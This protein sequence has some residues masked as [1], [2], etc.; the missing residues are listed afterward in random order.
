[1]YVEETN[2]TIFDIA[3]YRLFI[4]TIE[5][6]AVRWCKINMPLK[7]LNEEQY[8]LAAVGIFKEKFNL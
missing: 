4:H 3:E 1:V 5:E 8:Q 7:Q 6:A 2:Q